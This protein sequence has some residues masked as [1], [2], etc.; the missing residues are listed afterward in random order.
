MLPF[1]LPPSKVRERHHLRAHLT[2]ESMWGGGSDYGPGSV[3]SGRS[4][5]LLPLLLS[6]LN[7]YYFSC[8]YYHR[9]GRKT[10]TNSQPR[11]LMTPVDFDV[12]SNASRVSKAS[13]SS[14]GTSYKDMGG[15]RANKGGGGSSYKDMGASKQASK[16]GNATPSRLT[17]SRLEQVNLSAPEHPLKT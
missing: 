6:Y 5:S 2:D 4:H 7:S 15:S 9:S 12:R 1:L 13:K 17:V 8:F 10:S 3:K 16:N 14:R 11:S